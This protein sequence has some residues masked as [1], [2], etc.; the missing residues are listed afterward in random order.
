MATGANAADL[1]FDS[2][3]RGN[4]EMQR[5]AQE[6]IDPLLGAR[7]RRT[8]SSACTTS[9]P[10]ACPTPS[11]NWWAT[12]GWVRGS[13]CATVPIEETGMSPREIWCNES[14]GALRPGDR[15]GELAL[16]RSCAQRERCPYAVVGDA[17]DD[18]RLCWPD[19]HFA[20]TPID[21]PME[22]LL[23]KPPRDDA[24][25]RPLGRAPG[26]FDLAGL[27]LREA[28]YAVLRHPASPA[29]VP[30]HHRRPHGRRALARDQMVGPWQV[31]VADVAVTL[32]DL[33]RPSP[34][35]RWPWASACR[36][37]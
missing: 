10:A 16:L 18:G 29:S 20:T 26:R 7:A 32:A 25:R 22:V 4:P 1:D 6:V 30:D 15:P 12:P 23:G 35:R 28:A 34:A 27:D 8:P 3:Q 19:R 21:M 33:R 13:T 36:S 5:R 24:R 37:R 17:T 14:A 31:P 11:P 2:V 9:A